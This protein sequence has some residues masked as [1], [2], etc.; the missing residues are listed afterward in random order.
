ML[1][2]LVHDPLGWLVVAAGAVA[3][4]FAIAISLYWILRPG[5]SDPNH[6]KYL[7]LRDDR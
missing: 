7:I 1:P 4:A 6:P 3:T 2:A 5:E